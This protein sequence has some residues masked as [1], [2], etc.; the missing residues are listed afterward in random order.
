MKLDNKA[1]ANL[2]AALRFW[3]RE[4][5]DKVGVTGACRYMPDHFA[6]TPPYDTDEIDAMCDRIGFAPNEDNGASARSRA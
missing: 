5:V 6:D 2:L 1:R 3:Q 4:V